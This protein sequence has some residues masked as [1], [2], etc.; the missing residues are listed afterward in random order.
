MMALALAQT[1]TR[2]Q[3]IGEICWDAAA[4]VTGRIFGA[5]SCEARM[6]E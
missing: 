4:W 2:T 6:W 1:T 3:R 5:V